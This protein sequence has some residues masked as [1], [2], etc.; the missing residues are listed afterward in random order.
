MLC[1]F[2]VF[3]GVVKKM[4]TII[5]PLLDSLIILLSLLIPVINLT[6]FV[7]PNK[8]TLIIY[9]LVFYIFISYFVIINAKWTIFSIPIF[10][11]LYLFIVYKKILISIVLSG[12]IWM[13]FCISDG[14]TGAILISLLKYKYSDTKNNPILNIGSEIL[15]FL[16]IFILSKLIRLI[17]LKLFNKIDIKFEIPKNFYPVFFLF[18]IILIGFIGF[19]AQNS[20]YASVETWTNSMVLFNAITLFSFFIFLMITLY[21]SFTILINR[22]KANEYLQLKDYTN[23]IENMYSDLRSFK[24]DYLNIL[25]TL[26]TYIEKQ[27][28]N[29]LKQFYYNELLPE[30]NIIISKDISLSLL[31][32]IKISPLKALLSSKFTTAHSHGINVS[33]ELLDDIDHINMSTIDICRISGILLDNAI[34]A[35]ILCDNKF[36]HFA[37]IKTDNE[38]ILNISN[39]CLSSTPPI[40][41]IYQKNFSTKGEG[42][43]IGLN[44]IKDIIN[45]RYKNVLFNTAIDNCIFKQELIINNK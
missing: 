8:K 17:L 6:F 9:S 37:L 32:H 42:R 10:L 5:I 16:I 39:S 2:T 18:S 23:M 41:K 24:H 4:L 28:I 7:K 40:H 22:H 19:Q 14:I 20:L 45:K 29:G 36:I 43:G 11:L 15:I 35:S 25:S 33:I 1:I 27:D 13:L 31:S 30:S 44:N 12:F 34:D 3:K 38:I 21:L 26:E